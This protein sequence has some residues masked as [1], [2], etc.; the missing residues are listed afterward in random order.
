LEPYQLGSNRCVSLRRG[1]QRSAERRDPA[2]INGCQIR[3]HATGSK[4]KA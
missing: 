4:T 1:E 2:S 3:S